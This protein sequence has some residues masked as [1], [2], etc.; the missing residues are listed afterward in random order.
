MICLRAHK[1]YEYSTG[2]CTV[3]DSFQER[4]YYL[5]HRSVSHQLCTARIVRYS[6]IIKSIIIQL[7]PSRRTA[8]NYTSY[9]TQSSIEYGTS[10]SR[11]QSEKLSTG[12]GIEGWIAA[13]VL[14][15]Y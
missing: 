9:C 3:L 10:K 15:S 14:T 8:N 4:S 7:N 6:K 2:T 5:W 11:L 1:R 12:R 13:K